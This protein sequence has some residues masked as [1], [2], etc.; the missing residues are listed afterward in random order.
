MVELEGKVSRL[1]GFLKA[2]KKKVTQ[3]VNERAQLENA[4]QEKIGEI[5]KLVRL[6]FIVIV[7]ITVFI[8]SDFSK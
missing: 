2:A 4:L 1:E 6:L 8:F 3:V 7:L 5:E